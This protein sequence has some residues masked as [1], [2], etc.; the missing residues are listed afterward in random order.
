MGFGAY[1]WRA[2][3]AAALVIALMEGAERPGLRRVVEPLL[4]LFVVFDLALATGDLGTLRKIPMHMSNGYY[5][6]APGKGFI[7]VPKETFR[8]LRER[9]A[10]Q[11]LEL[12][13]FLPRAAT[14]PSNGAYR[15]SCYETLAPK[16]WPVLTR[17]FGGLGVSGMH[18]YG[19]DPREH[20]TIYDVASVRR[21][22]V[23]D[24]ARGYRVLKNPNALPRAYL[25]N[26]FEISQQ[27]EILKRIVD[28][29]PGF[30]D[31]VYLERE[32]GLKSAGAP[33]KK[34]RRARIVVYEPERVEL[35]I[36]STEPA[37]LILTDSFYPGWVATIDGREA[38]ILRA[39]GLYRAIVVAPGDE[40]VSFEYRPASLRWGIAVSLASLLILMATSA[41]IYHKQDARST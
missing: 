35:E 41:A 26:R 11:R 37:L 22:I 24:D 40:R 34:L 19:L 25:M 2:A 7:P 36:D 14:S 32:P 38:E 5:H 6:V 12:F 4:L 15:M 30:H 18:L 16:Q 8:V 17:L 13:R 29:D 31:R 39:N 1:A 9:S 33:W 20:E 27:D 3:V 23:P 21:V 28:G 10:Y